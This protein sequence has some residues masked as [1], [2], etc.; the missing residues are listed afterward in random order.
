MCIPVQTSLAQQAMV[1]D[2]RVGSLA[3]HLGLVVVCH[4]SQVHH[5]RNYLHEHFHHDHLQIHHLYSHYLH[6]H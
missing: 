4:C 3:V 5:L 6:F 2:W 1:E